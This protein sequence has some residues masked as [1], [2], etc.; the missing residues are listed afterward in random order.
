MSSVVAEQEKNR[1]SDLTRR[2]F[3][4]TASGLGIG[5]AVGV[6][7]AVVEAA[8]AQA[9]Q[10]LWAWC[11]QCAGLWFTSN[12]NNGYCPVGSGLFGWDHSH[13][14]SGSG[15]YNLK[16]VSDGGRGDDRWRFCYQCQGLWRFSYR[17]SGGP[18]NYCLNSP[19]RTHSITGSGAYLIE[20]LPNEVDRGG[21][22]HLWRCCDKCGGMFFLGNGLRPCPAG[23]THSENSFISGGGGIDYLLRGYTEQ[24][25][26]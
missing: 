16:F 21:G 10:H 20:Y 17:A 11:Y 6:T 5:V 24:V 9:A 14:K 3:L 19:T 1:S 18:G 22:Q 23:G 12:G 26:Q 2:S 25:A 4:H 8:P 15:D 7:F 13:K